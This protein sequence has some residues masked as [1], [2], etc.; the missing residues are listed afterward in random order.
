MV[1]EE[2]CYIVFK[3]DFPFAYTIIAKPRGREDDIC[4]W[5]K[6]RGFRGY[7]VR[8]SNAPNSFFIPHKFL[9]DAEF[10]VFKHNEAERAA[11]VHQDYIKQQHSV[12]ITPVYEDDLP[13]EF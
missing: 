1:K 3:F 9:L 12:R 2:I 5:D 7:M 13:V 6:T 4:Y 8:V 10:H 11:Q